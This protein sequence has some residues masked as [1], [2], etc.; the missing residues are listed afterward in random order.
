MEVMESVNKVMPSVKGSTHQV[1]VAYGQT[2]ERCKSASVAA[3]AAVSLVEKA[4]GA[5]HL[6]SE[7]HQKF[8]MITNERSAWLENVKKQIIDGLVNAFVKY[9]SETFSECKYMPNLTAPSTPIGDVDVLLSALV[10]VG[11][12]GNANGVGAVL[13]ECKNRQLELNRVM[14]GVRAG[15]GNSIKEATEVSQCSDAALTS[16][17]GV[18]IDLLGKQKTQLCATVLG[19]EKMG[20]KTA[21]LRQRA[22]LVRD[23]AARHHKRATEAEERANKE[24]THVESSLDLLSIVRDECNRVKATSSDVEYGVLAVIR[25]TEAAT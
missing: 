8:E 21:K 15:A 19:V 24:G 23:S 16:V 4:S 20:E 2:T 14:S 9:D 12:Y 1:R 3:V 11:S 13:S 5:A 25:Q 22:V 17:K 18:F 10:K 6:L 7:R